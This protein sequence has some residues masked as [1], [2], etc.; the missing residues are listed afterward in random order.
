MRASSQPAVTTKHESC[1]LYPWES[2]LLIAED[3]MNEIVDGQ[4]TQDTAGNLAWINIG[5]SDNILG[6]LASQR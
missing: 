1:Q 2:D 4:T 5:G 6:V 3:S